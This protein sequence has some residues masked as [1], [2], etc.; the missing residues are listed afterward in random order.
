MTTFSASP[1]KNSC[2]DKGKEDS[3]NRK[4][5]HVTSNTI[6]RISLESESYLIENFLNKQREENY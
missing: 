6:A 3:F 2:L 4:V 1:T 5:E